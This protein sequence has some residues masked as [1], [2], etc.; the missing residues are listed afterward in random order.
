MRGLVPT[1]GAALAGECVALLD[2]QGRLEVAIIE[3]NAARDL[4]VKAGEP[5][6]VANRR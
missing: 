1:Y 3:G 5:V 6:L 2:S 4:S